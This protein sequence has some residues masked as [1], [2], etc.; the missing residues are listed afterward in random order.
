MYF[1]SLFNLHQMFYGRYSITVPP[2]GLEA[3]V[4]T[5]FKTILVLF[6]CS[7]L[8]LYLTSSVEFK[9]NISP[10]VEESLH[11]DMIITG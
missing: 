8:W 5:L 6:P 9:C 3:C 7:G 2:R 10:C 1:F 11:T 4:G